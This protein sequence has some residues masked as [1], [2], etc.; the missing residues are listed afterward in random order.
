MAEDQPLLDELLARVE[1]WAH[2]PLDYR[3]TD[4]HTTESKVRLL[5]AVA[6]YFNALAVARYGGRAGHPRER[7]LIEQVVAA[8]FQ[9]FGGI[10][11]HPDHFDKAAMLLRGITQG[12]PFQDGNKRTGFALASYYLA[13]MGQ[14]PPRLSEDE[15]I[16]FCLQV[17]A[18]E[19]RDVAIMADSLRRFWTASP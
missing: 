2:E 7:G 8:T 4:P 18:G 9:T 6:H 19:I 11:P 1:R 3:Q 13:L 10:D 15:V 12:H 17:S 14:A 5:T 16:D